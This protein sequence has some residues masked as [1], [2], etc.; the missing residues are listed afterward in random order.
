MTHGSSWSIIMIDIFAIVFVQLMRLLLRA[1]GYSINKIE[2][3]APNYNNQYKPSY[4]CPAIGMPSDKP[5]DNILFTSELDV[6]S[7]PCGSSFQK[8]RWPFYWFAASLR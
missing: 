1:D 2:T 4:R 8:N 5:K 6:S 7:D 3:Y